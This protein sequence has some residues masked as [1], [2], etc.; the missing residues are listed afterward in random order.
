M[1][2]KIEWLLIKAHSIQSYFRPSSSD[3]YAIVE[4]VIK[5][6]DAIAAKDLIASDQ[7]TYMIITAEPHQL[8]VDIYDALKKKNSTSFRETMNPVALFTKLVNRE[9]MISLNGMNICYALKASIPSTY[10]LKSIACR[11]IS[12][13]KEFFDFVDEETLKIDGDKIKELHPRFDYSTNLLE[14]DGGKKKPLTSKKIIARSPRF[15]I[16][17][18]L[19]EYVR[20]NTSISSKIIFIN[21]LH[22]CHSSAMN[23]T[24]SDFKIKDA[25][26]DFLNLLI[27]DSYSSHNFKCI[28]H[29]D[30]AV[31]YDFKMTKHSCFLINK[32]TK[33]PLYIANLYNSASYVPIPCVKA[34]SGN[35]YLNIAHPIIK[36]RMLYIDMFMIE[37]KTQTKNPSDHAQIYMNKMIKAYDEVL[38]FDKMP[39]WIGVYKDELYEKNQINLRAKESTV[40]ET[41][42]L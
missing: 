34:I 17:S 39:T 33:Q 26:V 40:V 19:I 16:I 22:E 9:Y 23:I 37:H 15:D 38:K 42:L 21:E 12:S 14:T 11:R 25:I 18:R 24:Y 10:L 29:A 7:Y 41:L 28:R 8:L 36:L 31:P 6:H 5:K 30:F 27:N 35:T 4:D 20:H 3:L 13:I 1:D 2:K 32:A